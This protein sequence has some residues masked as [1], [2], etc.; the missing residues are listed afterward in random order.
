RLNSINIATQSLVDQ[1]LTIKLLQELIT[2]NES[3]NGRILCS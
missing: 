2:K 1:D 3:T